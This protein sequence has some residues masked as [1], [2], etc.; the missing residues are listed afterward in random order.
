[1]S[2]GREHDPSNTADAPGALY[3]TD[4]KTVVLTADRAGGFVAPSVLLNHITQ[5]KI[6][7][8]GRVVF[9]NPV[10]GSGVIHEGML[11]RKQLDALFT[12][13]KQ[14]G[15]WSF[16]ESYTI[17]GPSDMPT[18]V[19]TARLHGQPEKRVGCYGG[20]LSAPPG[21]MD[22]FEALSYPQLAPSDDKEYVRQPI[23]Q[24]DLET[25]WY[26]GFEYQKKLDTPQ[27]WVWSEAGRSSKWHKAEPVQHLVSLDSGYMIPG[28]D[29]CHHICIG[30][31]G[32]PTAAG[33]TIQFDRNA[34]SPDAFG[35][36][37]MTT[38]MYFFPKPATFA[39]VQAE[40]NQHL[41]SVAVEGY[42]GPKLRLV[43]FGSLDSPDCGRLLVFDAA[44]HIQNIYHLKRR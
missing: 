38:L 5:T 23:R 6:Y 33:A 10:V 26:W 29:G 4:A 28:V 22:C 43:I 19:I 20:A 7:G 32:S 25:G 31:N 44:D 24:A 21:F 11:D 40:G 27:D 35:N 17:H 16:S 2:N 8:D 1:M 30:Y 9:L 15:F 34:M 3:D 13:L 37:G 12:L 42:T 41:F 14:K 39:S 18:S 36:I